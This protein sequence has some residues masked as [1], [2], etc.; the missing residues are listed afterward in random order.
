M[1]WTGLVDTLVTQSSHHWS[2]LELQG[3]EEFQHCHWPLES[4]MAL[5]IGKSTQ[6]TLVRQKNGVAHKSLKSSHHSL[7]ESEPQ[8]REDFQN[9]HW[10]L[11]SPVA[12]AIG[13]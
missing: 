13:K 8:R 9:Y 12:L 5:A 7:V 4:P 11:E 2:R 3:H 1:S 10:T 6:F